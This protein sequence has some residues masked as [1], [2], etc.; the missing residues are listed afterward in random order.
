MEKK[1]KSRA[2]VV[3]E[4]VS[5]GLLGVALITGT[6][7]YAHGYTIGQTLLLTLGAVLVMAPTLVSWMSR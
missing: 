5:C 1:D 2:E 3:G 6:L 7:V 4:M